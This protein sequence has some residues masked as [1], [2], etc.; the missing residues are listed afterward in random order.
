[1]ENGEQKWGSGKA[2]ENIIDNDKM[3]IIW[4]DENIWKNIREM[5]LS[6]VMLYWKKFRNSKD[7]ERE[8]KG[9]T[10]LFFILV[11]FLLIICTS[12]YFIPFKFNTD[13]VQMGRMK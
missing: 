13:V 12:I 7:V 6:G 10:P 1:M 2:G 5:V 8:R 4:K 9:K 11:L 3:K